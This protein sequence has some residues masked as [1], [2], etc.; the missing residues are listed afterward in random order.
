[1]IHLVGAGGHASVV[2][3]V[4]LRRGHTA[5]MLWSEREPEVG[6]FPPAARWS[7]LRE[8]PSETPV[9][10]AV[11]D[12]GERAELRQRY[13]VLAEALVDSTAVLG[14]GVR[15]GK[16]TVVMPLC[17]LNANARV[18]EDV[19]LNT[20]C[21]VEHD[22]VVGPNSHVAPGVRLGGGARVGERVLLGTGAIV[23]PGVTVGDRAVVGAGAVVT[24]AVPDDATVVGVPAR[25]V[26]A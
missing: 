6:R 8:L 16:G 7:P 3:D 17:V 14:S 2:A 22:C 23:L 19:I 15:V 13:R 20:G 26:R 24:R 18:A 12:L 9:L 21:I 5:I 10:L 25:E 11:G 4:A 1:M